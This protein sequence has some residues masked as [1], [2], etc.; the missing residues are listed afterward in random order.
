M[1]LFLC[2]LES[3]VLTAFHSFFIES[4]THFEFISWHFHANGSGVKA[5]KLTH[6]LLKER[7][8]RVMRDIFLK[9]VKSRTFEVAGAAVAFLISYT[10]NLALQRRLRGGY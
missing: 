2:V 3:S 7:K 8:T 4:Q 1:L 5:A 6:D 9:Q 10:I